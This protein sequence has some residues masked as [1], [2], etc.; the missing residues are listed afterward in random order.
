MAQLGRRNG[1]QNQNGGEQDSGDQ[2]LDEEYEDEDPFTKMHK[3]LPEMP[4]S[5]GAPTILP[6]QDVLQSLADVGYSAWSPK[7]KRE[8]LLI[9][10]QE[11]ADMLIGRGKLI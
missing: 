2:D 4:T 1:G 9:L 3:Y 11:L 10:A 8:L 6:L 7:E 5:F